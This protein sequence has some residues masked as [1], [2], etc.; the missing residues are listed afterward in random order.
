MKTE[1]ELTELLE[2]LISRWE[3]EVVEFKEGGAGFSTH[4]IGKYF[5]ALSNEANLR[6]ASN[7]WLVFGVNNK[8]RKVVGSAFDVS[9]E[10]LNRPGG[11]KQNIARGTDP[12][13]CFADIHVLDLPE[14]RVIFFQIP[15]APRGIPIAWQG[16]Y[17]ARSGE[18]LM[19][20][21]LE[22]QDAIR[23][24]G[25]EE[26]WSAVPV[27]G[28]SFNDLDETAVAKARDGFAEKN[29]LRYAKDVVDSWDMRTFL[30]RARLTRNGVIT[31][32]TMLLVGKDLSAHLLTPHPAQLVWKLVGEEQANEIFYPPFLLA[33]NALYARIRNVQIKILPIGELVPREVPKYVPESVLEAL[34]NC[35]AHQDYRRN[36]RIVVTEYV[37]RIEFENPGNFFEGRP[38]DYISGNKTPSRY[39]NLQLVTAMREINM[40]DTQGYGIHRLYEAQRK[41]YFPM[42]DYETG[43]DYVK[44]AIYGHVVDTAYSSLLIRRGDL[45]LDDVCLLDRVQKGL[46]IDARAAAHLRR[47]GLVEGRQPRLHISAAIAAATGKKAEYMKRKELPGEHYR[48]LLIDF[49]RRF[50]GSSRA[51]INEFMLDEIRGDFSKEQKISKIGNIL[52]SLRRNGVIRNNGTDTRPQ[53]FLIDSNCEAPGHQRDNQ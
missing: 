51:E 36:G 46:R 7:G 19:A 2:K 47:E 22:K 24:Q 15:A 38:E 48:R 14:G 39:R 13:T 17:Y 31:R 44:T 45:S 43:R 23:R 30:D 5:S 53:W 37:D 35:I 4:D 21:G 3:D 32:T 27:E 28:A 42:P 52:T 1:R 29:A 9:P 33:T 34:H 8:T 49:L 10:A 11:L 40:I 6:D 25:L 20:L 16:H 50:N 41:R 12:A 26:D 18:N